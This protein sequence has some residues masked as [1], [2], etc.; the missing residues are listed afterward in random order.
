MIGWTGVSDFAG[1]YV[2]GRKIQSCMKWL[3]HLSRVTSQKVFLPQIDGLR[4]I[5]VM[6]VIAYHVLQI[7]SYHFIASLKS[8]AGGVGDKIIGEIFGAGHLGVPLFFAISGFML[9]LPFAKQYL[10]AAPPIPVGKYFVRR[11]TRIVPPYLIHLAFL[12]L[13]CGMVLR[14]FPSHPALYYTNAW[15]TYAWDHIFPSLVYANGF[16]FRAHPYPNIVLWALEVEIQFYILVPFMT[17]VFM[18]PRE[19]FRRGLIT[20][21]IL[22]ATTI[23]F[24]IQPTYIYMFS[25]AGNIQYFLIGFLFCDFYLSGWVVRPEQRRI[26]DILFLLACGLIVLF[27]SRAVNEIMLP[28]LN[29]IILIA[30]FKGF[31]CVKFFSNPWIVAIGGMCYT[32]YLYHWLMISAFVRATEKFQTHIFWFDIIMQFAVLSVVIIIFCTFLF[33]IFERPFMRNDWLIKLWTMARFLARPH[34]QR[35]AGNVPG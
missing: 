1:G 28:W 14:H 31:Y 35:R 8:G 2:N 15:A 6:G 9:S 32:I 29:L 33:A 22:T 30:A 11:I 16:L 17:S 25:L 18:I 21:A 12:F 10:C 7:C 34:S 26:W 5:A 20:V 3:N 19:R 4:F 23:G 24:V 13:L 27:Q